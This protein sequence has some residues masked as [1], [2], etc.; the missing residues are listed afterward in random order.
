MQYTLLAKSRTIRFVPFFIGQPW[1]TLVDL[2]CAPEKGE[3][4]GTWWERKLMRGQLFPN[5]ESNDA[6]HWKEDDN[7]EGIRGRVQV[8]HPGREYVEPVRAIHEIL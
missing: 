7:S 8:I 1:L 2:E 4:F 6:E 5:D 3:S